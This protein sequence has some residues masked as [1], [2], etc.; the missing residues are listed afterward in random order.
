MS[1]YPPQAEFELITD[2]AAIKILAK[3]EVA[4]LLKPFMYEPTSAT[5]A[6]KIAGVSVQTMHY[7]IGQ[8]L[9]SGLLKVVEVVSRQGRPIQ[10]YLAVS[11]AFQIPDSLIPDDLR[12]QLWNHQTWKALFEQAS[13]RVLAN[14]GKENHLYV[15]MTPE[16]TLSWSDKIGTEGMLEFL[17]DDRPAYLNYWN[18]GMRL[19]KTRAKAFQRDLWALYERYGHDNN[20]AKFILHLGLAPMEE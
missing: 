19:S 8:M 14:G 1:T 18:G 20:G 11:T 13:D 4:I 12:T 3:P 2:L 9:Q 5:T 10:K 16:G 6:C 17:P 15:F 7:R